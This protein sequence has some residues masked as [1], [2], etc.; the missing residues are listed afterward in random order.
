M[1][2]KVHFGHLIT[3]GKDSNGGCLE[4]VSKF[5]V[6]PFGRWKRD[7]PQDNCGLMIMDFDWRKSDEKSAMMLCTKATDCFFIEEKESAPIWH[8]QV[9]DNQRSW[10]E[11]ELHD[12][13]MNV[14]DNEPIVVKQGPHTAQVKHQV[15]I[16]TK[17]YKD[18]IELYFKY[19]LL[20]FEMV[21]C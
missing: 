12:H 4:C 16:I 1:E 6:F 20:R 18:T 11:K 8:F 21:E 15:L 9:I 5:I 13:L 7:S 2:P 10:Q 3:C 19:D 17:L 14:L